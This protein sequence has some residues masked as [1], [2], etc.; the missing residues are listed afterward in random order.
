M[1]RQVPTVIVNDLPTSAAPESVG[2]D[3]LTGISKICKLEAVVTGRATTSSVCPKARFCPVTCATMN[4]PAIAGERVSVELV[5][6]AI[7]VHP[8]TDAP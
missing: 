2:L 6:P 8:D 5:C 7:S 4:L 3:V 1:P